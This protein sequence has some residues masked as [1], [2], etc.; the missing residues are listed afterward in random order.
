MNDTD[1]NDKRSSSEFKGITFSKF[2]KSK[3][4]GELINSL[5]KSKIEPACYWT[6]ELICAGHYSDLWE[7]ILMFI[8]RYIHLGNPKL[9]IYISMRFKSFKEIISNGYA[10]NEL[11]MRNNIKI[12]HLFA[13][14]ISVLCHSRKKHSLEAIKIEKNDEFNIADMASRLKAPAV[15]YVQDI[16]KLDDPK[17]LFIAINEF[18]YHITKESKNSVSSCYW[19]EWILEYET[20]CKHKKELCIGESR[21]IAPIQDK[22]KNDIIWIVWEVILRECNNTKNPL[23]IKIV[24]ALLEIFSIKYSSGVKKRRKFLIYF[25]ISILT[26]PF[27]LTIDIINNKKELDIIIQKIGVVYKEIKKNEESLNVDYL[28]SGV[29]KT[30]LDKTVERL[31]KMNSI[32]ISRI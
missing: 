10:G 13:E 16:F 6:A 26:E 27:D 29:E 8:G 14:V 19:L 25:A 9:P 24:N 23:I 32:M 3:V 18:A 30:N 7:I 2:Q 20:L 1:I 12:R 21:Q 5:I 11:S 22:F 28:Y 4:K 17:E 15:T 31:E